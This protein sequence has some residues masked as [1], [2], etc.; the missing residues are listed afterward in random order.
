MP[1]PLSPREI[2]LRIKAILADRSITQAELAEALDY[3]Y[4]MINRVCMGREKI[5]PNLAMEL[6]TCGIPGKELYLCQALYMLENAKKKSYPENRQQIL[7][8]KL[9]ARIEDRY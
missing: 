6:E 4:V 2:G 3:S 8:E 9:F 5:S 7:R 1:S